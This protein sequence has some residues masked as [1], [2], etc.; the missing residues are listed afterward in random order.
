MNLKI[1][2]SKFF[3][4][5]LVSI[6]IAIEP[7]SNISISSDETWGLTIYEYLVPTTEITSISFGIFKPQSVAALI[8][9]QARE[10]LGAIKK[11]DLCVS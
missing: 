10:S 11:P 2:L 7:T 3:F 4:N 6:L 5:N 8:T 1:I 9:A